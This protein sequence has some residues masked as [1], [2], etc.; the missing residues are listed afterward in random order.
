M[1]LYYMG[2]A[3][4]N[5]TSGTCMVTIDNNNITNFY[6]SGIYS[7][8]YSRFKSVSYNN[9][10]SRAVS[11]TQYVLYLN[12]YNVID[13]GI[14]GN[15]ILLQGTSTG[16]A[17]YC[18]YINSS[19]Y[20]AY[21]ALFANNEIRK[22][23]GSGTAY[24]AYVYYPRIKMYNNSILMAGTG[25]NYG[26]YHYSTSTSY[27]CDMRNNILMTGTGYPIYCSSAT[28]VTS[29]YVTTDYNNYYSTTGNIAYAG[30][31]QTSLTSLRTVTGQD[32]HSVSIAP[33]W[34]DSTVNLELND[35]AQ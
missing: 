18:Y 9:F 2:G 26:I 22:I 19:S 11:A 14:I 27:S 3:T 16:Y 7:Y 31:A 32:V 5:V 25:T 15:K 34:T 21:P 33:S 29:T 13:S 10:V 28:Y 4:T 6:Y 20:A 1:Y 17:F 35:Y 23:G 8:Y 12:Y 24:G 30:T